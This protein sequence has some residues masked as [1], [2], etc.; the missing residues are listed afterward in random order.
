MGIPII[1]DPLLKHSFT[2]WI[3]G[4]A[5]TLFSGSFQDISALTYDIAKVE[6]KTFNPAS[7]QPEVQFMPGRTEP[8]TVTL[9][10]GITGEVNFWLWPQ[11]VVT[12]AINPARASMSIYVHNRMYLPVVGWNFFNVWPTKFSLGTLDATQS[13]FLIEE[14]TVVYERVELSVVETS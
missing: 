2:V 14:M 5:G 8:G 7:G 3:A 4:G 13:E 1:R 12:G 11:Q 6:Y 9:K 10:R